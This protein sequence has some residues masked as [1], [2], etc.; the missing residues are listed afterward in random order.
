M[1]QHGTF[2][3]TAPQL[4]HRGAFVISAFSV[5]LSNMLADV[6]QLIS[7]VF[8][9]VEGDIQKSSAASIDNQIISRVRSL[10]T[11]TD[12][13]DDEIIRDSNGEQVDPKPK[14]NET[15]ITNS[16]IEELCRSVLN[17]LKNVLRELSI[18]LTVSERTA[19]AIQE[20]LAMENLWQAKMVPNDDLVT[21]AKKEA[22]HFSLLVLTVRSLDQLLV[23]KAIDVQAGTAQLVHSLSTEDQK[24]TD[25]LVAYSGLSGAF[26]LIQDIKHFI[27]TAATL[28]LVINDMQ[29][30]KTDQKRQSQQIVQSL[31]GINRPF[32]F[33]SEVT[34]DRVSKR[35][36]KSQK[37][38][39]SAI[40]EIHGVLR[41]SPSSSGSDPSSLSTVNQSSL[42]GDQNIWEVLD[43]RS[44]PSSASSSASS[45]TNTSALNSPEITSIVSPRQFSLEPSPIV[46]ST[47]NFEEP[48]DQTIQDKPTSEEDV[49]SQEQEAT[50]TQEETLESTSEEDDL[51]ALSTSSS[52]EEKDDDDPDEEPVEENDPEEEETEEAEP[53]EIEG[54]KPVPTSVIEE[55]KAEKET[56]RPSTPT[57]ARAS[58]SLDKGLKET[59]G[60]STP[61]RAR[62][63]S[64]LDEGL[65]V[66][67]RAQD[68]SQEPQ[69]SKSA[70][71]QRAPPKNQ[72][73][74]NAPVRG[75]LNALVMQLT[76]VEKLDNNFLMTFINTYRAFTTP[77]LLFVKLQQRYDVPHRFISSIVAPSQ[78]SAPSSSSSSSSSQILSALDLQGPRRPLFSD[79]EVSMI[80]LRVCIVLKYWIEHRLTDFDPQLIDAVQEFIDGPVR[81]ENEK[82]SDLL[83]KTLKDKTQTIGTDLNIKI[84]E[85]FDMMGKTSS[86]PFPSP[87]SETGAMS[88]GIV[89]VKML[90]QPS[91]FKSF[92]VKNG[93]SKI[94]ELV[95]KQM[96]LIDSNLLKAL[97]PMGFLN[98]AWSKDSLRHR[99]LPLLSLVER[100]DRISHWVGTSIV[101]H[102]LLSERTTVIRFILHLIEELLRLNNY[103]SASALIVGLNTIP[104]SRLKH[105][106]GQLKRKDQK[107]M[108][109]YNQLMDPTHSYRNYRTA[110]R[111]ASPP[112]I[113]YIGLYL[114]DLTFIHEGNPDYIDEAQSIINFDKQMLVHNVLREVLLFQQMS[115]LYEEKAGPVVE[116]LHSFLL[117][118]PVLH[119]DVLY[120]LS[121]AHEPRGCLLADVS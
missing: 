37:L 65:K 64:S 9:A 95:A 15:I 13:P 81:R 73:P 86:D 14:T 78:P 5:H 94:Y 91:D 47:T 22:V 117:A 54:A 6:S 87:L 112:S 49:F 68:E 104:V 1:L 105:S 38:R 10:S 42:L 7:H 85:I 116:P 26:S 31:T 29:K 53:T 96:T 61:T 50:E 46:S 82:M 97:Q 72:D 32:V 62:A 19:S 25:N 80:K 33:A 2:S 35:L 69:L 60:P 57:R 21:G 100:L 28:R 66:T 4:H 3:Q 51:E 76:S 74:V 71:S 12:S 43:P 109:Q 67:P 17:L 75:T 114:S 92:A 56:S 44:S 98:L 52:S 59:S 34:G 24:L 41:D 63:S 106:F 18:Q 88:N 90:H 55:P 70:D 93:S 99:A 48:S 115:H 118:L 101:S 89:F 45:S 11:A 27:E 58:S 102:R 39:L 103:M 23:R 77:W 30:M 16:K 83:S 107:M 8:R 79:A 36:R 84:P 111:A 20:V 113:P 121:I 108:E 40:L 110:L 120:N 119:S